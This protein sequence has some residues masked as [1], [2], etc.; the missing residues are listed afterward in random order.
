MS[1]KSTKLVE[2]FFVGPSG[3]KGDI[4][5]IGI[6]GP[7]GI[8][9]PGGPPG[10]MGPPGQGLTENEI[11]PR[12]LWCYDSNNCTTQNS[13][14]ARY[15][16]NSLLYLGPNSNNQGIAIGGKITAA[17]DGSPQRPLAIPSMISYSNQLYLDAG[18]SDNLYLTP[19]NI[20]INGLGRSDTY[21]NENGRY[22]LINDKNG[23]V[24]INLN[25]TAPKNVLHISGSVPVTIDNNGETGIV[26]TDKNSNTSYQ[27]G[28]NRYGL[29]L[30]DLINQKYAYITNNGNFAVGQGIPEY[31]LDVYGISNFRDTLKF[32]GG[33]GKTIQINT[34]KSTM[35][36]ELIAGDKTFSGIQYYSDNF[37]FINKNG[38][39]I[40]GL[41]QNS[42]QFNRN[43]D[44][45]GQVTFHANV[46]TLASLDVK[47]KL[48]VTEFICY[49]DS[50]NSITKEY[51]K[52]SSGTIYA[53]K[54][55]SIGNCNLQFS[56]S[57]Y[58]LTMDTKLS[59]GNNNF[60]CNNITA[61]NVT[62]VSF[63][64]TSDIKLKKNIIDIPLE[65][66]NKLTQLYPKK[67]NMIND[68]NDHYGFIAQD[69]ET[70]YPNLVS[71]YDKKDTKSINY[72]ELIPIMVQQIN[73]LTN[74]VNVLKQLIVSQQNI[75]NIL[76]KNK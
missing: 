74:E 40:L 66:I 4:G 55:M 23:L 10:P 3:D 14:T 31:K 29:Y 68:S 22:T 33:N 44:F 18:N 9:G 35:G 57:A 76:I 53:S 24:G 65:D 6:R 12:T 73:N 51:V 49:K 67:Y 50:D 63:S 19:G 28:V 21:I 34:D 7:R 56:T 64:Q 27:L 71:I 30:Y 38:I 2:H 60:D 48:N 32:N 72:I 43:M 75:I 36:M 39:R 59:L 54:Y 20:H 69:I 8:R 5:E 45:Y 62:A 25:G 42:F 26:I 61:F 1:H 46:T 41:D 11:A 15:P 37:Y 52:I 16:S 17:P 47:N 70:V 13:I 58:M